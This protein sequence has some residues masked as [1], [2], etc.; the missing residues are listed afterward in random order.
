MTKHLY[1]IEVIDAEERRK[2]KQYAVES[3]HDKTELG[4]VR[5]H[6]G[7]RQ[8]VFEPNPECVWSHDC[9]AELSVFV[10]S[11]MDARIIAREDT[12]LDTEDDALIYQHIMEKTEWRQ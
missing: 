3:R 2:T 4:M 12:E 1:F 6:T 11:L 9:L 10:K 7:W 5:W 8:Y